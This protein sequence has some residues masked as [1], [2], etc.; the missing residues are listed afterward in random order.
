MENFQEIP[1]VNM[2]EL[3]LP[4]KYP[5]HFEIS[6]LYCYKRLSI[7]LEIIILLYFSFSLI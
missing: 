4:E 7:Q 2:K 6:S 3:G 1:I 5:N